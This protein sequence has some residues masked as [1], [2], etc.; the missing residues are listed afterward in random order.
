MAFSNRMYSR[1]VGRDS[2]V[3]HLHM[4]Y[5][6]FIVCIRERTVVAFLDTFAAAAIVM[7]R[8]SFSLWILGLGF[9]LECEWYRLC[10][11]RIYIC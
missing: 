10:I 3:T 7:R 2:N 5:M 6:C 11:A 8:C 9:S 4:L 1:Y